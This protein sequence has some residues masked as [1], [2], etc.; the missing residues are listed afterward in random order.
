MLNVSKYNENGI[1]I[2]IQKQQQTQK[3]KKK[4]L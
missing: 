1:L 4:S 3:H 2:S